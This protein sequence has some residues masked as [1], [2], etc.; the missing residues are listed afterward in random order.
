[1][2]LL[3][4]CAVVTSMTLRAA[5]G[6]STRFPA[7][8]KRVG[9]SGLGARGPASGQTDPTGPMTKQGRRELRTVRVARGVERGGPSSPLA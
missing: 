6:D 1:M 5:S 8:K 4:G 7:A 3:P 2:Q 9:Y